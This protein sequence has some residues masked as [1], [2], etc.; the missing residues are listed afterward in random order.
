MIS[1]ILISFKF[2]NFVKLDI[3]SQLIN[4]LVLRHII[5][6]RL[7]IWISYCLR[8]SWFRFRISISRFG[9]LV[10]SRLRLIVS[11]FI[12]N[13]LFFFVTANFLIFNN[14]CKIHFF[15]QA[16]DSTFGLI[17]NSENSKVIVWIIL[18]AILFHCTASGYFLELLSVFRICFRLENIN[19]VLNI[20]IISF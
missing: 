12:R 10:W 18:L 1:F 6:L 5:L 2:I 15:F 20:F 17:S 19:A 8:R 16:L 13:N 11:L 9:I 3:Q 14:I 7:W 4:F